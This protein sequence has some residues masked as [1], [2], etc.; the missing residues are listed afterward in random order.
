MYV[1]ERQKWLGME[2]NDIRPYVTKGTNG[3]VWDRT[4]NG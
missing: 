1:N 4:A 3:L 2:Q